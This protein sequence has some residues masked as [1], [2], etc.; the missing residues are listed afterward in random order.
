M[1]G[2]LGAFG[3]LLVV[4]VLSW[5][6]YERSSYRDDLLAL[7]DGS[8]VRFEALECKAVGFR[9]RAACRFRV[10]PEDLETLVAR[11]SLAPYRSR[12]A[13]PEDVKRLGDEVAAMVREE[14]TR[15]AE[16][17][18]LFDGG[19]PCGYRAR[20]ARGD[21]WLIATWRPPR[22]GRGETTYDGASMIV[23]RATG[24]GCVL[25]HIAY[26]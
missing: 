20:A 22:R 23:D 21:P 26:G 11:L 9:R 15:E 3:L 8:G 24:D 18:F 10:K 6:W 13:T 14:V 2:G 7:L 25:L 19:D 12:V 5:R 4:A 17:R 1:I 16:T